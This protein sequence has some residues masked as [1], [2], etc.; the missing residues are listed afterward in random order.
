MYSVLQRIAVLFHH[1]HVQVPDSC[2]YLSRY[3]GGY[4]LAQC[5]PGLRTPEREGEAFHRLTRPQNKVSDRDSGTASAQ[6]SIPFP[7]AA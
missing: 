6:S 4:L 2:L 1:F 5:W 3:L 7:S